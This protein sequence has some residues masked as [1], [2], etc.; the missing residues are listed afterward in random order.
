MKATKILIAAILVL[1]TV[2]TFAQ[3]EKGLFAMVKYSQEMNRFETWVADKHEML[4]HENLNESELSV[5]ST[6]YYVDYS[7]IAYEN[8]YSMEPWMTAPFEEA[9]F[10]ENFPMERWMKE[11]F[12]TEELQEELRL[13][14]WMATSFWS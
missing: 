9:F 8:E 1:V 10:E 4:N 3:V 7:N 2:T 14:D 11:P 12:E 5:I 6:T 13:E